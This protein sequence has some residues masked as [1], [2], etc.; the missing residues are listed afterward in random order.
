[1][2][3]IKQ[4]SRP[5]RL[6]FLIEPGNSSHLKKVIQLNSSIWGGTFNPIIPIYKNLPSFLKDKPFNQPTARE[7]LE[8]YIDNFD[9]DFIVKVGKVSI[10]K[11][12]DLGNRDIIHISE[13]ESGLF[14]NGDPDYA[15]GFYEI[16]NQFIDE[17]LKYVR[18]NPI[19]IVFPNFGTSGDEI[20]LASVFGQIPKPITDQ[21]SKFWAKH[22]PAQFPELKLEEYINYY[23]RNGKMYP[24]RLTTRKLDYDYSGFRAYKDL[25]F[26]LEHDN[27][28]DIIDYW[29]LRAI[30]LRVIPLPLNEINNK[31]ITDFVKKEIKKNYYPINSNGV[32]N[33]TLVLKS[34][35]VPEEE[36]KGA[37]KKLHIKSK[38]V[39]DY[40]VISSSYPRVWNSWARSRDGVEACR[41]VSQENTHDVDEN[42]K[43]DE[44]IKMK[45][46]TPSFV[47]DPQY[48]ESPKYANEIEY[49]IFGN[50]FEYAEVIPVLDLDKSQSLD[51]I[52]RRKWRLSRRGIHYL[53]R[54]KRESIYFHIPKSEDVFKD[55][56]GQN[57][58]NNFSISSAG[59]L[60]TRM[61]KQL[62]DGFAI[63]ILA[64][65]NLVQL[66]GSM[67]GNKVVHSEKVLE[68]LG[69]LESQKRIHDRKAFLKRLLDLNI[70]E[71]GVNLK[72]DI[73][74]RESFH[75]IDGLKKDLNCPKCLA[76]FELPMHNPQKD[77]KWA[78]T[79]RGTFSV[80]NMGDGSV[81]VLLVNRFFS[82]LLHGS[83]T[84][85][86]S[87]ECEKNDKKI[88]VDGALFFNK[89]KYFRSE[90]GELVFIE[91][92]S[93]ND[94]EKSDIEKMKFLGDEFPG[95]TLV[96]ATLK[97]SLSP[98]EIKL[99]TK[100]VSSQR[101]YW[102]DGK[103]LNKVLI[104]TGTELLSEWGPSQSWEDKG[105]IYAP[106]AKHIDSEDLWDYTQQIYL[107]LKSWD[108]WLRERFSERRKKS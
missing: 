7:Y 63:R 51:F 101:K 18:T 2:K 13:I 32:Y 41:L 23:A 102:K 31:K 108:E 80:D 39:S 97:D 25:V 36:F 33:H 59:K 105:G 15:I 58:W 16:L 35:E 45:V 106:F 27:A 4:T 52:E 29:N 48:S 71:L 8:G 94:F 28:Q 68:E 83:T 3:S 26:V 79:A 44:S 56:M 76:E 85:S 55:F 11:D 70:L 50:N 82:E 9:P 54:T 88:E 69:R 107:G 10:P 6:A 14:S 89:S 22:I 42:K 65:P 38:K 24:R 72:C 61:T 66:I 104:L 37:I 34:R 1:M 60:A 49:S 53:A 77:F 57:G 92:K 40:M 99:L 84:S 73:C 98:T 5:L 30:G 87:F 64:I 19:E 93:F 103:P 12:L 67:S 86:P 46:L 81:C 78:Y 43:S 91:A 95:C 62:S 74:G 21:I 75:K 47:K 90:S 96:F 17:E 20:F 100:L